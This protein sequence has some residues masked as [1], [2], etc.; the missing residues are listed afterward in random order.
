VILC[1]KSLRARANSK[2]DPVDL[3]RCQ[4]ESGHSGPCAEF[5][6][7]EQ[8]KS[9]APRVAA[10]IVRDATKTTGASW[11]SEDAG[12]NRISRWVMLLSDKELLALGVNMSALKPW[13]VAKLRQK[14][15]TYDDCMSSARY[16]AWS[17]YGMNGAPAP[18]QETRAYL[19]AHFGPIRN[20]ATGCLVCRA[21][22][23]FKLFHEARRGKAEIE[24]AH[25]NPREHTPGNV[26]FAHRHCNIAQ[27]DKDLDGFYDW[28]TGILQRAGRITVHNLDHP[29]P[30]DPPK[31]PSDDE[32]SL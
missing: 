13:V 27:G 22:M 14:A 4:R 32:G 24:T 30:L 11:K 12:P 21:P 6:Y 5:H 9:V 7:L 25:A 3:H 2:Y 23:D 10:K 19:E 29:L 16:L 15:A 17:V 31:D 18:D 1:G 8:L 28:I 26:G 20:G